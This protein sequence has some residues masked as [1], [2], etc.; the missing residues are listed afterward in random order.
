MVFQQVVSSSFP[1]RSYITHLILTTKIIKYFHRKEIVFQSG[2]EAQVGDPEAHVGDPEAHVG[3]PEA[4]V[5]DPEAH[6][7]DP[8]AQVGG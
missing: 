5:G 2:P 8:E 7:G 3:D 4:Q 1:Q 6:V